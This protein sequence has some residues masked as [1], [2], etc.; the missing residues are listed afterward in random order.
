MIKNRTSKSMPLI[1][2][3]G[4]NM[5]NTLC[6]CSPYNFYMLQQM[7]R[8][9][10]PMLERKSRSAE[11]IDQRYDH[12]GLLRWNSRGKRTVNI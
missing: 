1:K 6:S 2:L 12:M 11:V 7:P 8:A 3:F 4:R 5:E 10:V 9:G